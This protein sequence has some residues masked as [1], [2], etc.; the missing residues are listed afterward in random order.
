MIDGVSEKPSRI[1]DL[2][3]SH[4]LYDGE[5]LRLAVQRAAE[6]QAPLFPTVR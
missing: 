2:D 6:I 1:N 5:C 4:V 3:S